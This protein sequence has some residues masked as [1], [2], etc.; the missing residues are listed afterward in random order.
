MGVDEDLFELEETL[1]LA[2]KIL[3]WIHINE[4]INNFNELIEKSE[5]EE[6]KLK[7]NI[8]RLQSAR[9]IEGTLLKTLGKVNFVHAFNI[10]LTYA[11]INELKRILNSRKL[12]KGIEVNLG[13]LK[14]K[15]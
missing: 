2:E 14:F 13:A 9:L 12:V 11:G 10:R 7:L 8:E 6:E 1:N 15:L 3:I 4:P 5:V